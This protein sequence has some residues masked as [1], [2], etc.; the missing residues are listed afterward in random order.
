MIFELKIKKQV[1]YV[2]MAYKNPKVPNNMFITKL[3]GVYE[4]LINKAHEIIVLGDL[5]IDM[6][7]ENNELQNELCDI[8]DLD[9]LISEP[10]CFKRLEGTLIDPILVRN[11]MRFKTS[12]NVFCGYSD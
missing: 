11:A 6:L 2:I 9:N 3:K 10:T 4:S 8:Y 12:I 7:K 1:W 5:N